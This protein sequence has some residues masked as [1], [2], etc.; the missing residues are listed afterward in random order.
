MFEILFLRNVNK[1]KKSAI[2]FNLP[3]VHIYIFV[4]MKAS[5]LCQLEQ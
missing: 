5:A 4:Y 2:D 3:I 1:N